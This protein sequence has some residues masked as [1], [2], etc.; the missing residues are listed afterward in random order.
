MRPQVNA[1]PDPKDQVAL[2]KGIPCVCPLK[3]Y[4]VKGPTLIDRLGRKMLD[5]HEV[6]FNRRLSGARRE[7]EAFQ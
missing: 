3:G 7:V 1:R 4:T 2:Y 6:Q 5:R